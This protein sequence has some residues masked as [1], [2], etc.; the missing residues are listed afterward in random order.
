MAGYRTTRGFLQS[1]SNAWFALLLIAAPGTPLNFPCRITQK[2]WK[3]YSLAMGLFEPVLQQLD[4][5]DA[6]SVA[7]FIPLIASILIATLQEPPSTRQTTSK[8]F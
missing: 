7:A 4:A 2:A 1:F 8:W 5:D 3:H 6:N